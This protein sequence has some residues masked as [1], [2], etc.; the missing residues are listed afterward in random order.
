MLILYCHFN[1]NFETNF[2]IKFRNQVISLQILYKQL[3]SMFLSIYFNTISV[4]HFFALQKTHICVVFDN[5][6]SNLGQ[7]Y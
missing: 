5:F 1:K 3:I 7:F 6:S 4:N 2:N